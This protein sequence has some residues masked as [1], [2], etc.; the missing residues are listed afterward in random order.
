MLKQVNGPNAAQP[1]N[2]AKHGLQLKYLACTTNA[3]VPEGRIM[4]TLRVQVSSNKLAG[5]DMLAGSMH[6]RDEYIGLT[7]LIYHR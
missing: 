3:C 6:R 7:S 2:N 4:T 5:P 1:G